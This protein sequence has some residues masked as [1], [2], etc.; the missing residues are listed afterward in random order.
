[1]AKGQ[2]MKL[3]KQFHSP[4]AA[5]TSL[6]RGVNERASSTR[7]MHMPKVITSLAVHL[8]NTRFQPG[9]AERPSE[10]TVLTVFR[11]ENFK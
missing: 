7:A 10:K 4:R 3:L 9:A 8:I 1:V 2:G 11:I 5:Y 6:K